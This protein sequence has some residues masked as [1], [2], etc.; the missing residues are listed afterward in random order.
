MQKQLII[1]GIIALFVCV[2]LSGCIS[3]SP[4]SK[5]NVKFT[6]GDVAITNKLEIKEYFTNKTKNETSNDTKFVIISLTI[7][8]KEN[9]WLTVQ[10]TPGLTGLIDDEGNKYMAEMFV[11]INDSTY[12]VE[13]ISSINK[14]QSFGFGTDIKPNSTE[15]KKIV[16]T[17]PTER[18]P[19]KLL[20]SYGLS[21]NKETTSTQWFETEMNIPS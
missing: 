5:G 14:N 3:E 18:K 11:K 8:N 15:V 6:I 20:L 4:V 2:G 13:Q 1:I 16:F 9:K 19:D 21:A 12:S 17:L 10:T 7:E